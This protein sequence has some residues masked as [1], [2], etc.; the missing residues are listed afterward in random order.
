MSDKEF[1]PFKPEPWAVS[2]EFFDKA[3]GG[4]P[5]IQRQHDDHQGFFVGAD[6]HVHQLA[7]EW[8]WEPT[9]MTR[10]DDVCYTIT[11]D[12]KIKFRA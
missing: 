7:G 5:A 6:G 9:G 11:I 3:T 12:P 2:V 10:R 4:E 1:K 8:P